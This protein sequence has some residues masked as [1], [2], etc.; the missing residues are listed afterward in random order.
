MSSKFTFDFLVFEA[1]SKIEKLQEAKNLA[2]YK[3]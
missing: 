1:K 2:D 3:L